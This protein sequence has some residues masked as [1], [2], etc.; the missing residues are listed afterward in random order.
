MSMLRFEPFRDSFRDMDRL[1]SQLLSGTRLPASMPMD[2]WRSGDTYKVALDMPGIEPDSLEVTVERGTLTVAAERRGSFPDDGSVLLAER[3]QGRFSRQLMLG[4][5]VESDGIEADY[6]D[7][8]L[9]LR[10]PVAATAKPRRVSVR[11]GISS[12][13]AQPQLQQ[14]QSQPR[15]MTGA[16]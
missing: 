3:P 1:T 4:E 12:Q 7:G 16:H 11:H 2:V 14:Q 15:E 9:W 6:R 13:P 10:I 5:D 8:V